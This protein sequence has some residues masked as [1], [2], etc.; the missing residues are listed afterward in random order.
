MRPY[1][2]KMGNKMLKRKNLLVIAIIVILV[3]IIFLNFNNSESVNE[4]TTS[5]YVGQETRGI[6]SL[7]QQ[8]I[9]GLKKGSGTPFGGMAKLAELNG[10]PGPKHVLDFE[11]K[12]ELTNNQKNQIEIIY[13]EMKSESIIL[14]EQII[15]IEQELDDSFDSDSITSEYLKKKVDESAKTYGDLRNIHLQAHLEMIKILTSEQV[16]KYN[17]LRGYSSNEDPCENVPEGHDAAMWKLHNG[18]E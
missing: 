10:Y 7:S 2:A 15:S 14:G 6:K 12:L 13:D 18:C 8:D 3:G 16:K 11:E 9:E 17:D 5:P 1:I 4:E